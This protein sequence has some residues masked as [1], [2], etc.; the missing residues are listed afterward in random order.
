MHGNILNKNKIK[1]FNTANSDLAGRIIILENNVYK[2][3]YYEIISG[4]SGTLT[5]PTAATINA[6]EFSGADCI[7]SEIDGNNKPTWI[8]PKTVGGTVVTATLNT[9]TGAWVKSGVTVS[10]NVALIYSLNIRAA[11]YA[12]L[13]NFYIV[14]ETVIGDLSYVLNNTTTNSVASSLLAGV[15]SDETGTGALVF[16]TSPT[17]TTDI[18]TPLIIGAS[19]FLRLNVGTVTNGVKLEGQVGTTTNAAIYLDQATPSAT[20]YALRSN[21]AA[22]TI[23]NASTQVDIDIANSLVLRVTSTGLTLDSGKGILFNTATGGYIGT[24]TTQ[25]IGVW[26]KTPIVQPTTAFAAATF[27]ANAGTAVN[28]ASTF[29]GYTIKQVVA[30]LRAIGWL[31]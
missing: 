15:L 6:D 19:G 14:D 29:D 5:V 23:L 7:L 28:D 12:N 17:F 31:A 16:G 13:T 3:T 8:S 25:K 2:I 24:G 1:L 20:N 21:G 11:D 26:A 22:T 27:V 9:S 10:A 4:A 18:T 30:A